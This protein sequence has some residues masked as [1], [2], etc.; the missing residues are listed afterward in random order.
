[1][2]RKTHLSKIPH[3]AKQEFLKDKINNLLFINIVCYR[4]SYIV[5]PNLIFFFTIYVWRD[6]SIQ[7]THWSQD[8]S[9]EFF[10]RVPVAL[11]LQRNTPV[12]KSE[13]YETCCFNAVWISFSPLPH[14]KIFP[15]VHI[16]D[17][18]GFDISYTVTKVIFLNYSK[19]AVHGC[20]F[21]F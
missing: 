14:P 3:T 5:H 18:S 13:H 12:T 11:F 21:I 20:Y 9:T 15:S 4:V 10:L 16:I 7:Q 17:K 6:N 8:P 2:C 1:M 19:L